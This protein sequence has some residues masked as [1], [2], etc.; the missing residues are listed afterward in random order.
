M[1]GECCVETGGES[2]HLLSTHNETLYMDMHGHST[3]AFKIDDETL[4]EIY[5]KP[6]LKWTLICHPTRFT[7]DPSKEGPPSLGSQN[8]ALLHSAVFCTEF[9]PFQ[10]VSSKSLLKHKWRE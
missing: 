8:L 5:N 4:G 7:A 10:E 6:P 1:L 3:H 9:S 2:G